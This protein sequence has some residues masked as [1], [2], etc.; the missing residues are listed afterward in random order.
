MIAT[1]RSSG[2]TAGIVY[3]YKHYPVE[4]QLFGGLRGPRDTPTLT[5]EK[6]ASTHDVLAALALMTQSDVQ[7]M[8]PLVFID[9]LG[10]RCMIHNEECFR[11]FRDGYAL[12]WR[13]AFAQ[14]IEREELRITVK[15]EGV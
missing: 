3:E 11:A 15:P 14:K 12:G 8:T 9:D 7:R 6:G 13:H 5:V 10:E 2:A 4:G 1:F